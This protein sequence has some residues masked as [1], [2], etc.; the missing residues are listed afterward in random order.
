M[1]YASFAVAVW[2]CLCCTSVWAIDRPMI[3]GLFHDWDGVPGVI[4][5]AGDAD[6]EADITEI[7]ARSRGTSLYLFVRVAHPINLADGPNGGGGIELWIRSIQGGSVLRFD[8]RIK[9]PMIDTELIDW[10]SLDF[11]A[12]PTTL[13]NV[14]ELRVDL[15][16]LGVTLGDT[17]SISSRIDTLSSPLELT[18]TEPALDLPRRSME[19]APCT[20]V[21]MASLNTANS[22]IFQTSRAPAI[23]RLIASVDADVYLFQEESRSTPVSLVAFLNASIPTMDGARWQVAKQGGLVIASRATLTPFQINDR[24]LGAGVLFPDGRKL[25]VVNVDGQC[26]GY[27]GS[28]ADANRILSAQHAVSVVGRVHAAEL[29]PALAAFADAPV[30]VGGDW[31][32][33]GSTTPRDLWMQPPAALSEVALHHLIGDDI[34]TWNEIVQWYWLRGDWPMRSS[35]FLTQRPDLFPHGGFVLDS[36]KLSPAELAAARLLKDDS[37]ASGHLVVVADFGTP[38]R[39]D[40]SGDGIVNDGDFEVFAHAYR[41]CSCEEPVMPAGCP[42]DL[43]RDGLVDDL[44]FQFFARAYDDLVCP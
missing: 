3:D 23:A 11:A 7:R 10:T 8:T 24:H 37:T 4:D 34:W 18:L 2:C 30:V 22:G 14:F 20:D 41:I 6:G 16:R 13:S 1:P 43:N 40:L 29:G 33:V 35:F 26:C 17:I 27:A 25:L 21:R 5:P 9:R 15:S 36:R 39:A 44:D 42:A 12:E 32:L 19:R 31:N 38:P 28:S